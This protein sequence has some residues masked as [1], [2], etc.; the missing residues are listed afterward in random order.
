[1][2]G[3]CGE[4]VHEP[5]SCPVTAL[6]WDF[7]ARH[8]DRF[9]TNRRMRMPLRTLGRMQPATLAAHRERAAEFRAAL[10]Q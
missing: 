3:Y 5:R 9:A 4:C 10:A 7:M 6:Y 1:M 2:S 8:R